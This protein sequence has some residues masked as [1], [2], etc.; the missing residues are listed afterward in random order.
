[1]VSTFKL[2]SHEL[3]RPYFVRYSD[4]ERLLR[5]TQHDCDMAL[6]KDVPDSGWRS[7]SSESDW[8]TTTDTSLH[9][10]LETNR[11]VEA[12]EVP[13]E[14]LEACDGMDDAIYYSASEVHLGMGKDTGRTVARNI[15]KGVLKVKAL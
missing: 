1:M 3:V 6:S 5:V 9:S 14:V 7:N 8:A 2:S 12:L 15:R 10:S 11:S 13:L 4:V